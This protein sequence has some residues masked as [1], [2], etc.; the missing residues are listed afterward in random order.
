[1]YFKKAIVGKRAKPCSPW[2]TRVT[3][4]QKGKELKGRA[5][6][7]QKWRGFPMDFPSDFQ[8]VNF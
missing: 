3:G 4:Q 5:F 2:A 1:M 8:K 6:S 7:G